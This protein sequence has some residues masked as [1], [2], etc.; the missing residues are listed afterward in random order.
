MFFRTHSL[1]SSPEWGKKSS[2]LV[3]QQNDQKNS[4]YDQV[5][6]LIS[7]I[8]NRAFVNQLQTL[9]KAT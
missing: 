3:N 4:L 2:L 5:P 9:M 7:P 6:K 1:S 8:Y